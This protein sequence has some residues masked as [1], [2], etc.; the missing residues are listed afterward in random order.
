MANQIGFVLPLGPVKLPVTVADILLGLAFLGV[1]VNLVRRKLRGIK[2][3]PVQAFVLVAV[4][5]VALAR[6]Q[7]KTD[8]AKEVLQLVEYF[9]VAFA[10]FANVAATGDLRPFVV[11]FAA[12]TGIAV[13]WGGYHYL[14]CA[15]PFDVS[16][17]YENRNLLCAFFAIALP[18]LYGIALH[19]R[20]WRHRLVLL[21]IVAAGLVISLSGGPLLAT[22]VILALLSAIRGGRALAAYMVVLGLALAAAPRLLPRL[23]PKLHHVP[24][25]IASV[26]PFVS[27]NYLLSDADMSK[28]AKERLT[29]TRKRAPAKG[30]KPVVPA[31]APLKTLRLLELLK[32][33][34]PLT[35]DEYKGVYDPAYG[36]AMDLDKFLDEEDPEAALLDRLDAMAGSSVATRYQRWHAAVIAARMLW[37]SPA[38]ESEKGGARKTQRKADSQRRTGGPLFGYGLGPYHKHFMAHMPEAQGERTDE[39]EYFN[40]GAPEPFTHNVWLKALIQTGLVGLLALAWLVLAFAG[41]AV[42]V[43]R[44]AHSELALGVALGCFGAVLGFA[45]GGVFTEM[46]VRGLAIPFAFV[47]AAIAITER[48]VRGEASTALAQLT[49]RD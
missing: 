29:P 32:D 5:C 45:L 27:D 47:L 12:A 17:G 1:A 25:L 39:R 36:A 24:A 6:T 18:L 46:V 13:L 23:N 16:A 26:S 49:R 21:A 33:R 30:E 10:V 34:R 11:A 31:P 44:E 48:V 41:R 3:P 42:R 20:F 40:V 9:L 22:L 15:S 28:E 19:A 43:Y 4:A 35:D 2:L 8:G 7:D 38:S 37:A 14:T